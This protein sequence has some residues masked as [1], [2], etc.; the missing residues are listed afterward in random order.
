VHCDDPAFAFT[1]PADAK[2]VQMIPVTF[3]AG[4]APGKVKRKITI[5]TDLGEDVT[6]EVT[7]FAEV[8]ALAN[9]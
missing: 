1:H 8:T 3:V 7:A 4:K 5:K 2:N 9:Q 6:V